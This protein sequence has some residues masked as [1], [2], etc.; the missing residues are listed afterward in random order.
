MI[1]KLIDK[2]TL[3]KE[4][5]KRIKDYQKSLNSFDAKERADIA[6]QFMEIKETRIDELNDILDF[7]NTLEVKEIYEHNDA[8]LD[9]IIKELGIEPDSRIARMFKTAFY[10]GIDSYLAKKEK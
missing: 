3:V 6:F 7:V 5:N 1:M 2:D 10:K 9:R 8:D 4:I